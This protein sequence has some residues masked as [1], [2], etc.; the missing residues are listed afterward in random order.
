[1]PACGFAV[2]LGKPCPTCGMTTAFS[3]VAH[4]QLWSAIKVQPFA[5]GLA[6]VTAAWFWV[7]G[8]IAVTGSRVGS[9]AAKLLRPGVIWTVLALG[10]ASWGYTYLTWESRNSAASGERPL[11]LRPGAQEQASP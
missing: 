6:V 2:A 3:H 8:Y 4:G 1:M 9:H 11:Q 5:A 7:G 10:F